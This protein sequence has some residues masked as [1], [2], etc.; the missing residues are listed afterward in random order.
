M[1]K[2]FFKKEAAGLLHRHC[3]ERKRCGNPAAM[4]KRFFKKGGRWIASSSLRGAQR[5][6]KRNDERAFPA[7]AGVIWIASLT[8]IARSAAMRQSSSNAQ[9]L[10]QK[11]ERWIAS[12][13]LRG[14]QR[15]GKRN[16]D[17]PSPRERGGAF[18]APGKHI[19]ARAFSACSAALVNQLPSQ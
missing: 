9:A 16:D 2:R 19:V 12:S 18:G 13:S 15:R 8:V 3:E 14:A 11:G 6:G 1:R 17:R 7:R 4:R 5:R 10:L